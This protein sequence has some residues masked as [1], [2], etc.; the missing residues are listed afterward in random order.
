MVSEMR[1]HF[2]DYSAG[3]ILTLIVLGMLMINTAIYSFGREMSCLIVVP[4]GEN[5]HIPVSKDTINEWAVEH[6]TPVFMRV[7]GDALMYYTNE[8]NYIEEHSDILQDGGDIYASEKSSVSY[9]S[10]MFPDQNITLFRSNAE[11]LNLS[12][13]YLPLEEETQLYGCWYTKKAHAYELKTFLQSI[14]DADIQVNTEK[15]YFEGIWYM[16]SG[17]LIQKSLIFSVFGLSVILVYCLAIRYR[18]LSR[19]LVIFHLFGT[20]KRDIMMHAAKE[21]FFLSFLLIIVCSIGFMVGN[22]K[23]NFSIMMQSVWPVIVL[24]LILEAVSAGIGMKIL[25]DELEAR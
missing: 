23:L 25:T 20:S 19:D 15:S 11:L 10:H 4:S 17:A 1:K 7:V 8:M 16:I 21:Y 22:Q 13:V 12:D 9:N 18:T 2:I 24:L 3:M 14:G 6:N 5:I